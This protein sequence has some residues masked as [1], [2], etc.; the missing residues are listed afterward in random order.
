MGP[1][2]ETISAAG[3]NGAIIHYTPSEKGE[4][5][6]IKKDH[7]YLLD[8]GGQYYDGTTDITRTRHMGGNP[9]KEQ[10]IAFTRVLKGQIMLATSLFPQGVKGNVLDSFA[11]RALW[12][13]GLDYAHGT[14]HG[15]G[16]MLN[17]HEGPAGVSWRPY[18]HDPGLK[19]GQIL[20]N[21]PGYYKVG[22]FGIRHEDLVE[23]IAI[24]K[25]SD[26]PKAANLIGDFD[27]RGV[28]GFNTITLVPHQKECIDVSLLDNFELNYLNNYHKRVLVMVST[29]LKARNLTED[30][31]WLVDQCKPLCRNMRRE[32]LPDA[33]LCTGRSRTLP[34]CPAPPRASTPPRTSTSPRTSTPPRTS[35]SPRTST[36]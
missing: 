20:S 34:H 6:L 10:K 31:V 17:V 24:T 2:F 12:D 3:E 14:G 22:E 35:T 33:S 28:L 7:M 5:K 32:C 21:E 15:V 18:P 1:S 9:T 16:H 27:G 29:A 25:K 23:T 19:P 13:V 36:P 11:R 26:H 30:I 4:Q 8:S